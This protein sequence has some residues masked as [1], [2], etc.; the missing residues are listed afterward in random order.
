MLEAARSPRERGSLQRLPEHDHKVPLVDL[1]VDRHE[2]K[3]KFKQKLLGDL[4]RDESESPWLL[5]LSSVE[6]RL[7]DELLPTSSAQEVCQV[8]D[9]NTGG[10]QDPPNFS[11][12]AE[13]ILNI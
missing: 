11:Q 1:G 3:S 9:G 2:F 12:V 4:R 13:N 5:E 7:Q 6:L 10:L 8:N